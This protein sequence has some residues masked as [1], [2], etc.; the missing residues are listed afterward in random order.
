MAPW[1]RGWIREVLQSLALLAFIEKSYFLDITYMY[2]CLFNAGY[3][4]PLP[5][6][7]LLL[8]VCYRIFLVVI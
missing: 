2:C 3:T 1:G 6:N 4:Q 8:V 5:T 7:T